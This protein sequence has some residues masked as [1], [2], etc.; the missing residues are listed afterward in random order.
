[1]HVNAALTARW[2]KL[3]MSRSKGAYDGPSTPSLNLRS[4]FEIKFFLVDNDAERS[5]QS[6]SSGDHL[7]P[8]DL[9][10]LGAANGTPFT[11]YG[12]RSLTI[13]LGLRRAITWNFLIAEISVEKYFDLIADIKACYRL[14]GQPNCPPH[15]RH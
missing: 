15:A 12:T 11:V 7:L 1:M 14:I 8:T 13:D 5:L 9:D 10:C 4:L 3:L 6:R 2:R